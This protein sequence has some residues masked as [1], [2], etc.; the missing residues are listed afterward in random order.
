LKKLKKE[1]EMMS[2]LQPTA[3]RI[4]LAD[5]DALN[6]STKN[7]IELLKYIKSSCRNIERISCYSMPKNPY[8]KNR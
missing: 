8:T 2:N 3:T 4:F 1:I 7:L 6:V 5:G